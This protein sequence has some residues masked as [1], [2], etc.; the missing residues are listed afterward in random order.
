L[1]SYLSLAILK[2][3]RLLYGLLGD[4]GLL[5]ILLILFSPSAEGVYFLIKLLL[6]S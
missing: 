6:P 5:S 2:G 1:Y 3:C 4:D